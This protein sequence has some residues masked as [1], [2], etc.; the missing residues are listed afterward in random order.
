MVSI[1]SSTAFLGGGFG[2]KKYLGELLVDIVVVS[3]DD[4]EESTLE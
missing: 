2:E 4:T 3:N 1:H